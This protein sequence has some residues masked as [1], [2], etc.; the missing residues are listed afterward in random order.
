MLREEIK[1][2]RKATPRDLRKFGLTVGGVFCALGLWFL[3][4][5]KPFYWHVL[6]PGVP[7][8]VL[9][10]VLPRSLKW[11]YVGWMSLAMVLGV[12]VSTI[13]LTLLFF[14]VVTPIGLLAR[15]VG[16]DF[17]H[18]KLQ[19]H[20]VSYWISRDSSKQKEKERHE[21]QF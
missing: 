19:P 4:R 15:L 5:H 10:T 14:L 21:Q 18:R 8:V 6:S 20:A 12:I 3:L 17:L 13:L 1:A 2:L 9:G 11:L 16:K 7:L